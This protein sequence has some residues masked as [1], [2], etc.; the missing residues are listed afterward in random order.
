MAPPPPNRPGPRTA[1]AA[2]RSARSGERPG[3]GAAAAAPIGRP[4][5]AGAG[6]P[7]KG[8]RA[9]RPSRPRGSAGAALQRGYGL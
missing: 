6:P 1:A 2:P 3:S 9:Q 5:R 7:L 8:P 4:E